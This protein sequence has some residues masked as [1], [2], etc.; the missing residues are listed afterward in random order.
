MPRSTK[1]CGQVVAAQTAYAGDDIQFLGLAYGIWRCHG[2]PL[3]MALRRTED[4]RPVRRF[5]NRPGVPSGSA[6]ERL[7]VDPP[8]A[9][10]LD[11][12]K[13]GPDLG[14][15]I[16]HEQQHLVGPF[17][18]ECDGPTTGMSVPGIRRPSLAG[19]ASTTAGN[20]DAS[21]RPDSSATAREAA[22]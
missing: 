17:E 4:P 9:G 8:A 10:G 3:R 12:G 11:L 20:S 19:D 16:G 13:R 14:Q 15:Q 6:A 18:R 1:V 22:P 21:T 7:D 2:A 5:A